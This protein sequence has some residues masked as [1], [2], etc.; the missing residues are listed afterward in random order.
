MGGKHSL[1][2]MCILLMRV[3]LEKESFKGEFSEFIL[4][5]EN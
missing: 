5:V 1:G 2:G 3:V 4:G